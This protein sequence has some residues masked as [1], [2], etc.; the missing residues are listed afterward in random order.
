ML[1]TRAIQRCCG[2]G[3]VYLLP[4][5]IFLSVALQSTYGLAS[6]GGTCTTTRS[7]FKKS[8]NRQGGFHRNKNGASVCLDAVS[9]GSSYSNYYA[10]ISNS[11]HGMPMLISS[12]KRYPPQST[13]QTTT[14]TSRRRRDEKSSL[15]ISLRMISGCSP[16]AV[17]ALSS[18]HPTE[19]EVRDEHDMDDCMDTNSDNDN[20]DAPEQP[21][22]QPLPYLILKAAG[23]FPRRL[24]TFLQQPS[25]NTTNSRG[26]QSVS[27]QEMQKQQQ[28]L[29]QLDNNKKNVNC[30]KKNL[31][32]PF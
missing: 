25:S 2:C 26:K 10:G 19:G 6:V 23:L 13:H 16:V 4:F 27:F 21:R 14:A 5:V 20:D 8:Y 29:Q 30:N 18:E 11:T 1:T 31:W 28:Q 15:I 22:R 12:K 32:R 24:P 17:A 3:M 7:T 9:L